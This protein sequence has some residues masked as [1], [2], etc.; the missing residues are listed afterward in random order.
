MEVAEDQGTPLPTPVEK[1]NSV[2]KTSR[3]SCLCLDCFREG[4]KDSVK[5]QVVENASVGLNLQS[6]KDV[7]YNDK[8]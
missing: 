8:K 6:L 5:S 4:V 2:F 1:G 7:W 3:R